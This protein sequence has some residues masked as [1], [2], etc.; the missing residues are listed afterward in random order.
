MTKKCAPYGLLGRTLGHSWSPKIHTMLGSV[1]YELFEREPEDVENFIRHGSWQGINVTIPYKLDA[2]R[3]ADARTS[4]VE[5][6][7]AAN[8]L[9]RRA[10]GTILAD[11][12]DVLG[13][14][15][16]LGRFCQREL[17]QAASTLLSGKEA[18]VLGSGGA[19]KAVVAALKDAGARP[20]VISRKGPDTYENLLER[21]AEAVL[22]VNATPVGMFPNCPASPLDDS[23]LGKLAQRS[24]KGVLDVVYNPTRTGL[25][26]AAERQGLPFAS[27]LSMLVAQAFFSSELFQ[28]KE[29]DQSLVETIE[30]AIAAESAN[31]ILIG[32][33]GSGKTSTGKRLARLMGRPFVDIDDAIA[34]KMGSSAAD[35]IMAQG[36]DAFRAI[37]TD[38]TGSYAAQSGLVIACGGGVVTR[39]ENYPLLHQN[40]T[41]VM[42]DRPLDELSPAGRPLSAKRGIETLAKERMGAYR[43]WADFVLPTTGSSMGDAKAILSL[44]NG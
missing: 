29:L 15:W 25:C 11:N 43:S 31:V 30:S 28:D 4:R 35:I 33:P 26:L 14:S 6:M 17:G 40:G 20:A 5:R 23:T 42:L 18:L 1:P 9:V 27:G 13:F 12:T 21:H 38:I 2:A 3:L 41:I 22:V 7:G 34:A 37:E 36:E 10:D 24:L 32:M 19:S 16:M 8:T 44:I 39:P